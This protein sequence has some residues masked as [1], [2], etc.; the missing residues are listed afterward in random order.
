MSC[1]VTVGAILLGAATLQASFAD[2]SSHRFAG[3]SSAQLRGDAG[4][5]AMNEACAAEFGAGARLAT[6][7]E[8]VDTGNLPAEPAGAPA[9]VSAEVPGSD[10]DTAD[11]AAPD[12]SQR[13]SAAPTFVA[14]C[15]MSEEHE[16]LRLGWRWQW[17]S[18]QQR[19]CGGWQDRTGES[20]TIS[21]AGRVRTAPCGEA[22]PVACSVPLRH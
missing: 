10:G 14:T 13:A 22:R 20:L 11:S 18:V 19:D 8:I 3:F 7:S 9:W 5:Q 4:L 1:K 17:L 6:L 15:A 12:D 21:A 2:S 16:C